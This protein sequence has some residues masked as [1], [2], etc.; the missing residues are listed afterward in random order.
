MILNMFSFLFDW[1]Y[2]MVTPGA[3][4]PPSDATEDVIAQIAC[5]RRSFTVAIK[6]IYAYCQTKLF[7]AT[8]YRLGV[9]ITDFFVLR[10]RL[11]IKRDCT[12]S[13]VSVKI[14]CDRVRT[15]V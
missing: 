5:R 9:N 13:I 12:I 1:Y 2:K 14:R 10:L 15:N 4:R 7:L 6:L 8:T 11:G 3:G